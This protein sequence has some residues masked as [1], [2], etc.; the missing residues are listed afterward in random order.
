MTDLILHIKGIEDVACTLEFYVDRER[1]LFFKKEELTKV[2]LDKKLE[3]FVVLDTDT[4]GRG[5]LKCRVVIDEPTG[6]EVVVSGFTGYGIPC[7]GEGRDISCRDYSIGFEA[8]KEIPQGEALVF[9]G[10]TKTR[11]DEITEN[12]IKR[13]LTGYK[14]EALS[15]GVNFKKGESIVVA[16]PANMNMKGLKDDGFNGKAAFDESLLGYNGNKAV[17]VDQ[18]RYKIYGEFMIVDG[19]LNVFIL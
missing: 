19:A 9:V 3:Y 1:A 7:Y 11:I 5:N 10:V 17:N 6:Q 18:V 8:V 15:V 12:V 13:D 4:L 14:P 16:V 2:L